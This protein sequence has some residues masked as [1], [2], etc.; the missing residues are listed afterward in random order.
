MITHAL[1]NEYR[2]WPGNNKFKWFIFTRDALV[3]AG[4]AILFIIPGLI[5]FAE[6]KHNLYIYYLNNWKISVHLAQVKFSYLYLTTTPLSV[7]YIALILLIMIISIIYFIRHNRSLSQLSFFCVSIV[8][9]FTLFFTHLQNN[10]KSEIIIV[11]FIQVILTILLGAS[12]EHIPA[13]YAKTLIPS[14]SLI[15][16][17][18]HFTLTYIV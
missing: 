13:K 18:M 16:I 5:W 6:R 10:V 17:L 1:T 3:R 15:I 14:S 2:Y 8:T 4:I 11:Q 12:N 9:L 7:F